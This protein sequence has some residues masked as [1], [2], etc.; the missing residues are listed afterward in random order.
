M[1]KP[2]RQVLIGPD[3]PESSRKPIEIYIHSLH[4]F[5]NRFMDHN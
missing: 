2:V 4:D 5:Q 3:V 1:N